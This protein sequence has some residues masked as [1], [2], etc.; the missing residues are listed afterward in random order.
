[1]DLEEFINRKGMHIWT[2]LRNLQHRT[3]LLILIADFYIIIELR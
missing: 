1:M 2:D 3:D